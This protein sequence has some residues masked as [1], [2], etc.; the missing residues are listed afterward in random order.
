MA[1]RLG[2]LQVD[3]MNDVCSTCVQDATYMF[4]KGFP[5][6]QFYQYRDGC[7]SCAGYSVSLLFVCFLTFDTGCQGLPHRW[8][9]ALAFFGFSYPLEASFHHF[10]CHFTSCC[11][12]DPNA[13][14]PTCLKNFTLAGLKDSQFSTWRSGCLT[15]QDKVS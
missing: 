1:T 8:Q 14:C 4:E 5:M 3:P 12:Q 7:V 13:Q 6:D 11:L 2:C 9:H 15:C 10:H